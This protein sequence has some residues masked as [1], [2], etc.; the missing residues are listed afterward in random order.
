[1]CNHGLVVIE[2][3]A[4]VGKGTCHPLNTGAVEPSTEVIESYAGDKS[5]TMGYIMG[6]THS[7]P[8]EVCANSKFADMAKKGAYALPKAFDC[9]CLNDKSHSTCLIGANDKVNRQPN[10][11]ALRKRYHRR[12]SPPVLCVRS[13][14]KISLQKHLIIKYS[15]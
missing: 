13:T 6:V 9:T 15:Q 7:M 4:H 1:M 3:K 8:D 10:T 11:E 14:F 12:L 5:S 2:C